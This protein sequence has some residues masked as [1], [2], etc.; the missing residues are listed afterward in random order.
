[1]YF[2]MALKNVR[3]SFKDY[4]IYFLTL[5]L[6]VCIFYSFNSINSQQ[7]MSLMEKSSSNY[8]KSLIKIISYVSVFVSII[9]GCLV[10][11]AN[12]FLIKRRNREL[13]IYMTL[14]MSK[15]KISKILISET[16]I[17]LAVSLV[18]GFIA[19]TIASQIFSV[20]V[21]NLFKIKLDEYIFVISVSAIGKTIFYFGLIFFIVMVFNI[22]L[23]S[24]YKIIDLLNMGRKNERIRFNNPVVYLTAF[25]L[26]VISL[27]YSYNKAL[28]SHLNFE[29]NTVLKIILFGTAGTV[30]FFYSVSG[31]LLY[32]AKKNK[33]F[34]FKKLNI[35]LINQIGSK[36]KTNF[37]SMS[38]ISLMLFITIV[39]LSTG[40][41]M[42]NSMEASLKQCTPYDASGSIYIDDN[43]NK[44]IKDELKDLKVTN[45]LG[46][47]YAFLNRY[48]SNIPASDYIDREGNLIFLKESEYNE[49][50]RMKGESTLELNDHEVYILSAYAE[51]AETIN[52]FIKEHNTI[53][54]NDE[55][56]EIKND[57][58]T[59]E[60][61]TTDFTEDNLF[62]VVIN[63][64]FCDNLKLIE[65]DVNIKYSDDKKE[66][67]EDKYL[68]L[69]DKYGYGSDNSKNTIKVYTRESEYE[70]NIQ[71]TGTVLIA[72]IYLGLVFLITSMAVLAIHVL[73]ET[74]DSYGRYISLKKIG[75]NERMIN[76]TLFHYILIIFSLPVIVG[77]INSIVGIKASIKSALMYD[78]PDIIKSA[79]VTM[80]ILLCVYM[81]YFI[82]AYTGCKN[83]VKSK[84]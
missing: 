15:R 29:D 14:G 81:L 20:L 12:N 69:H 40:I 65:S 33:S 5:T 62:T 2:K 41:S 38:V 75:V 82:A 66:Q 54:I 73:C 36:V 42:K 23:V 8:A 44:S 27:A 21:L 72:V 19:G 70:K 28:T 1:M 53:N 83:I 56:Y 78:N 26:S 67:C 55:E 10:L 47:E 59:K 22:F 57:K 46:E 51:E 9:L 16:L 76:K 79:F 58:V 43:S 50:R 35:F 30:L 34:Y 80:F 6:A 11:Y 52:E 7:I 17:A 18:G 37:I 13:A 24:K 4:T 49:N 74:N 39:A 84:M 45:D 3:K 25:T 71:I 60:N 64:K 77:V 31:T 48:L 61:I 32:I 63:D 68:E